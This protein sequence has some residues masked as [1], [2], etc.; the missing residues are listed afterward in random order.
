MPK[1]LIGFIFIA[2]AAS[3]W[4]S[5]S[6]VTKLLFNNAYLDPFHLTQ[7]RAFVSGVA[8]FI[9]LFVANRKALIINIKSFGAFFL[10]GFTLILMQLSHYITVSLTDVSIA[11]F[12]QYLAPVIIFVYSVIF[13]HETVRSGDILTLGLAIT[14]VIFLII[15]SY[16]QNLNMLGI[17]G[18][19]CNAVTLSIY[20]L[21]SKRVADKHNPWTTLTYGLLSISLLLLLVSP[22]SPEIFDGFPYS[23][24]LFF[25]YISLFITI[26]PFGLWLLGLRFIKPHHASITSTLEPVTALILSN[27]LL[28]ESLTATKLIGCLLIISSVLLMAN[29]C[30]Q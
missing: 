29:Q 19:L 4:G 15:S 23:I 24:P 1:K 25:L 10:F 22:P 20:T 17:I 27:L 28:Q 9:I 16:Q 5:F 26:I 6:V 13:H 12:L 18:G 30:E 14:G 3:T 8:L 21:Y 11:S 7:L 2:I